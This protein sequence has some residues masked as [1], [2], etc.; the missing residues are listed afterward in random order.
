MEHKNAWPFIKAVDTKKVPDY[1]DV[2]KDPMGK[3]RNYCSYRLD[4]ERI[5]KNLEENIY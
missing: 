4:L 1:Y 3:Q 5:N 2:I